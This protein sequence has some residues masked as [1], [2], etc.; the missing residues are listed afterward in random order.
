MMNVPRTPPRS[1]G[2]LA[3][4]PRPAAGSIGIPGRAGEVSEPAPRAVPPVGTAASAA[5]GVPGG[6]ARR[7]AARR[8]RHLPL[9]GLLAPPSGGGHRPG[10]GSRR[11]GVPRA[12]RLRRPRVSDDAGFEDV[13]PR[14]V[15]RLRVPRVGGFRTPPNPVRHSG[16]RVRRVFGRG[17]RSRGDGG[18][19]ARARR[20]GA[21][22]DGAQ[23]AAASR[24]GAPRGGTPRRRRRR[25]KIRRRRGALGRREAAARPAENAS[26]NA[27]AKKRAAT[28]RR[29]GARTVATLQVAAIGPSRGAASGGGRERRRGGRPRGGG[30]EDA[31]M[32]AA[33]LER[34]EKGLLGARARG[35]G[36]PSRELA[37]RR[38]GPRRRRG[39]GAYAERR[40]RLARERLRA[41]SE[42]GSA[43][44][45]VARVGRF[46]PRSRVGHH[47]TTPTRA[48]GGGF[49]RPVERI[50]LV[51]FRRGGILRRRGEQRRGIGL[52]EP[53]VGVGVDVVHLPRLAHR[54][55]GGETREAVP[56]EPALG[57]RRARSPRRRGGNAGG[58]G[59]RV[60]VG[61]ATSGEGTV[62]GGEGPGEPG[63]PLGRVAVA[64]VFVAVPRL[65]GAGARAAA[66][67]VGRSTGTPSREHARPDDLAAGADPSRRRHV[68]GVARARPR[69]PDARAVVRL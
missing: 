10:G 56:R 19:G 51:R 29:G 9:V 37:P 1:R 53:P 8:A 68:G 5:R 4:A 17:V 31:M 30:D 16:S 3:T 55:R 42:T 13:L 38:G 45:R 11:R 48:R 62:G 36:R 66:A 33:R 63:D 67:R 2:T 44:P 41:L 6:A 28:A 39:G 69:A 60:L 50:L 26:H 61:L 24:G 34:A 32:D 21:V 35:T 64:F 54:R 43:A 47:P 59:R 7:A 25:G 49:E 27:G 12:S 22:R 23:A 20:F 52:G 18:A 40:R 15:G 57:G 65:L 58:R 14:V 46:P